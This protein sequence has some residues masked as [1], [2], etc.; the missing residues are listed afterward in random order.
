VKLLI[1]L[2]LMGFVGYLNLFG[3]TP[4]V[5]EIAADL[6]ISVSLVGIAITSAWLLSAASGLVIGPVAVRY[7][8]R[9]TIIFGLACIALSAIGTALAPTYS[10]LIA[11]R[12]IGGVGASV[13]AGVTLAIAVEHFTGDRRRMAL[14]IVSSAMAVAVMAG[15]LMLTSISSLAGWRGA[16]ISLGVI[17]FATVPIALVALPQDQRRDTVAPRASSPNSYRSL[18]RTTPALVLLVAC[19][20]HGVTLTGLTT[21]LGA[22]L[23][24]KHTLSTQAVG[25]VMSVAGAG[26]FLGTIVAG[27]GLWKLEL[28]NIYA[29]T[30]IASALLWITVY[31]M[32]VGTTGTVIS[33]GLTTLAAGL[34]WV[35]LITLIANQSPAGATML[36]V[37]SASILNFGSAFGSGLGS[38]ILSLAGHQTLGITLSLFVLI[39]APL[40][41]RHELL[42]AA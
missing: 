42:L 30:G 19:F 3:L 21:Y 27:R 29:L 35:C 32:P 39:A 40:V 15:L 33:I 9:R 16:L 2:C 26:Y 37:L 41:W 10:I 13:A 14:S 38:L 7:G 18:L 17:A 6:G 28:R 1:P 8:Q 20:L 22:F 5:I 4:F 24:E 34:G 23:I 31:A 12:I 25:A 36:M 11:S